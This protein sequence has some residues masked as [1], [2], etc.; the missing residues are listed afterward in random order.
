MGRFDGWPEQ[1]FDVLLRLD[2]E[3]T[4]EERR[5][6]RDDRERLVRQPMVALLQDIADMD[7]AYEDFFVWGFD[8][9]IWP[10]QRQRAL[11][12]M[13]DG[14]QCI[15]T[16]D[17]DGLVVQGHRW[18]RRLGGYRTAVAGPAGEQLVDILATLQGK[19][20]ELSGDVMER[21]PHGFPP[22]HDRAH[23]LRH[24]T[25]TATKDLGCEDW[26]HTPTARAH[27]F[28]ALEELRP[29]MRWLADHVHSDR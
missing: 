8:K 3:P 26:L 29:F 15:V 2:G 21:T 4:M 1:A 23:L 5:R 24:R 28:D 12:L 9:M 10:W 11:F 7:P 27:V 22:G 18:N 14:N 17:L 6:L 19:G 16:F 20:Y 13:G 25:L